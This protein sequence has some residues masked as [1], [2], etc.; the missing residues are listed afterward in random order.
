MSQPNKN[1]ILYADDDP[2]DVELLKEAFDCMSGDIELITCTNGSEVLQYLKT[3]PA[4]KPTP[5][6]IILD[7]NMPVLDGKQALIRMRSIN[8]FA[9]TPVVLF[10]TSSD[11]REKDFAGQHKAGF[12]TK[13]L[14]AKQIHLILNELIEHCTDEMKEKIKKHRKTRGHSTKASSLRN[15]FDNVYE[16][17]MSRIK[18][19]FPDLEKH[20]RASIRKKDIDGVPYAVYNP[21]SQIKWL[22]N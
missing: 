21:E 13:P 3:L 17:A 4:D 8:R 12:I 2:D 1:T 6:L 18:K 14:Y 11:T 5:C 7:I 20:L 16:I 19:E 9:E 10:S 15:N 22:V